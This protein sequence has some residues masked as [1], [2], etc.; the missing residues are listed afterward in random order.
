MENRSRCREQDLDQG[1]LDRGDLGDRE[2]AV[3][4]LARTLPAFVVRG[5]FTWP[6]APALGDFFPECGLLLRFGCPQTHGTFKNII[7]I[8]LGF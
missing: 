8:D 2:K 7:R 6:R 1:H 4:P 3:S 5:Q